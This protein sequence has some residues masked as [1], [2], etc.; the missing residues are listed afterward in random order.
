M[1]EFT[2]V[3]VKLSPLPKIFSISYGWAEL[4]QNFP[5]FSLS[6]ADGGRRART[7]EP[8]GVGIG[9]KPRR[10][11]SSGTVRSVQGGGVRRRHAPRPP[12]S[13]V[14]TP[15]IVVAFRGMAYIVTAQDVRPIWLWPMLLWLACRSY[16]LAVP[17]LVFRVQ[18]LGLSV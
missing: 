4:K 11:V 2:E 14:A 13:A 15:H 1:L 17:E 10:D 12:V 16:G 8:E 18:G 3:A 9:G 6:A 5:R 7:T